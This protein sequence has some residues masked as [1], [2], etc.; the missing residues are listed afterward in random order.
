MRR[1]SN[2][3]KYPSRMDRS[4]RQSSKPMHARTSILS[5]VLAAFAMAQPGCTV[6]PNYTRPE[7]EQPASFRAQ[8]T[9]QLTPLNQKEW[10][11]LY[12]DEQLDQLVTMAI[13]SNQNLQEAIARVDQA[14]SLAHVSASF[15][16]PTVT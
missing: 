16:L 13:E 15:L 6:G 9:T 8:P 10:W 5:C 3:L 2:S 1:S 12:H 4:L 14:R 7:V 11:R